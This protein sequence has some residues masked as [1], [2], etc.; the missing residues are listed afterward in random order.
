MEELLRFVKYT[1]IPET[2]I[3]VTDNL[4]HMYFGQIGDDLTSDIIDIIISRISG[5]KS[6]IE[7]TIQRI[8]DF[9]NLILG[10]KIDPYIHL[11]LEIHEKNPSIEYKVHQPCCWHREY[12]DDDPIFGGAKFTVAITGETTLFIPANE[13][14][15]NI[16]DRVDSGENIDLHK[17]F[18]DETVIFS[19]SN[20][21]SIFGGYKNPTI[22]SGP[23]NHSGRIFLNAVFGSYE[24]MYRDAI[25]AGEEYNWNRL[26]HEQV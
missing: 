10:Y 13:Y 8:R 19:Q 12:L 7:N 17:A 11:E 4:Y 5:D 20:E 9:M 16:M 1:D 15:R 6:E 3:I 25:C 23:H 24:E 26:S 22:H 18:K 2:Q 21:V 14:N